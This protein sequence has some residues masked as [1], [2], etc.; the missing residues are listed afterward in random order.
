[1][2]GL[3]YLM[4]AGVCACLGAFAV[5]PVAAAEEEKQ[6][7]KTTTG[8]SKKT[9]DG[10]K[11]DSA[12]TKTDDAEKTD[13]SK[14]TSGK[15]DLELYKLVGDKVEKAEKITVKGKLTKPEDEG[16]TTDY[17]IFDAGEKKYYVDLKG[18]E[19]KLVSQFK[20]TQAEIT[21]RPYTQKMVT[22]DGEIEIE[23]LGVSKLVP[24]ITGKVDVETKTVTNKDDE[25]KTVVVAVRI[26]V[27]DELTFTIM[28]GSTAYKELSGKNNATITVKGDVSKKKMTK[29]LTLYYVDIKSYE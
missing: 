8:D 4:L 16:A 17:Y 9:D 15:S 29:D 26:K 7:E 19:A 6:E 20:L 3:R 21:G 13:A 14:D 11:D 1:M 2:T 28:K 12:T 10:K 27:D 25:D 23:W 5:A 22:K 24:V 18:K